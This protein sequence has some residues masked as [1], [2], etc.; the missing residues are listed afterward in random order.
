MS[1]VDYI[2]A[3]NQNGS[4][5]NITQ[6]VDSLVE[7]ETTPEKERINKKIEENNASISALLF[8]CA[9]I[10]AITPVPVPTSIMCLQSWQFA[11]APK[12]IPSVPIFIA[13]NF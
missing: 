12:R 6:I 7:A 9:S 4:G 13:A 1:S 8:F 10:R 2:S 11:Q 3:L 5:L